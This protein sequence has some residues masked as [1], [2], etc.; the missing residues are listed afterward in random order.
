MPT[1]SAALTAYTLGFFVNFGALLFVAQYLQLVLGL[2]PLHAGAWTVPSA[3]AFI[4]GPMLTPTVVRRVRAGDAIAAGLGLA[5][6]GFGMLTQVT[7]ATGLAVLVSGSVVFSLGLA[8]VFTLATDL[9]VGT[10][11]PERAGA[12]SAIAE[13]G[14]E[15]GGALGIAI[16]GTVGT[17]VYRGQVADASPAGVPPAAAEVARDT[18]GGALAVGDGLPDALA[19]EL[20]QAGRDAFTQGL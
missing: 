1:F 7:S 20:L 12:A 14:S 16:L 10:A 3:A 5:A 2:S 19:A 11:S 17:A 6:V 4:V 8:T 15:L 9:M 13:T 18:L